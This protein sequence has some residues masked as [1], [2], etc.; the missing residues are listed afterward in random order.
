MD[1][2]KKRVAT[3]AA[4]TLTQELGI[5][6]FISPSS[7]RFIA[8]LCDVDEITRKAAEASRKSSSSTIAASAAINAAKAAAEKRATAALVALRDVA[9][10]RSNIQTRRAAVQCAVSIASGQM[11]ASHSIEDKALKLV[12]NVLFP[13]SDT[14]SSLVADAA[15]CSLTF[16]ADYAIEKYDDIEKAN[17]DATKSYQGHGH[18]SVS[19]EEEKAATEKVKKPALLFMALCVR[20]PEM[21][22][23]LMEQSC[24]EKADVLSK[25][26]RENM[27]K[28]ARAVATKYGDADVALKVADMTGNEQIPMLLAFLDNLAPTGERHLPSEDLIKA[29][30]KIQETKLTEDGK[31]DPRF[32]IPVVTGMKRVDLVEELPEFVSA[33]DKIFMAAVVHMGSR[34]GRHA[35]IFRDEPDSENPI[36]TGMTLCETFVFLHK[37]DFAAAGIPQKRYLD[38]IR[39]C[40]EDDDVFTD[41]VIRQALD[42]ISGTFVAEGTPLPLAYMRTIILMVS[43]HE[44]LHSWIVH[45]LLPRLID[46]KV[47]ETDKRQWEGWMR[48]AGMLETNGADGVQQAIDKLPPEQLQLYRSKYPLSS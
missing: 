26:V 45:T 19:S 5:L 22:K 16:A 40:L 28:L 8:G 2:E 32:I 24:R 1:V 33:E 37:L 25:A 11:P 12:M 13:K 20:R 6:P 3:L 10:Q 34:L 21:M 36:M 23:E 4:S 17:K 31:K 46:G 15:V 41:E 43:K 9:F 47:Y 7:L 35:L 14:I 39:L 27:P 44:S 48:C 30:H 29:C 42:Y 38:A 18:V